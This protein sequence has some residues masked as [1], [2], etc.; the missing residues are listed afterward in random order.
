[1]RGKQNNV[2]VLIDGTRS[3]FNELGVRFKFYPH[4]F[5]YLEFFFWCILNRINPLRFKI[6]FDIN[7]LNP[8]RDIVLNFSFTTLDA[9]PRNNNK[10]VFHKY[11][12]LVFTHI[13]HYLRNTK[14]IAENISRI[15][16]NILVAE[17]NLVKN[18]YFKHFFPKEKRVYQLPFCFHNRFKNTKHFTER[19]N[20]C[21]AVGTYSKLGQE[22]ELFW[23][24]NPSFHPMRE[25]IYEAADSTISPYIDSYISSFDDARSL[26]QIRQGDS[27][28]IKWSKKYLPYFILVK[29]IPN[30]FTR[31]YQFNI[32]EKYNEYRMFI[33]PEEVFGLPSINVFEGMACGSALVAIDDQMYKD[34]GLIPSFHYITYKE[35][36]LNDLLKVVQ[37]YQNHP[38][39][40]ELI[41]RQGCE[42]IREH[43]NEESV[44]KTF[45]KDLEYF[46]NKFEKGEPAFQ[47]SFNI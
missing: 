47:C 1:M 46:S 25:K 37:Y 20:K 15:S 11:G 28:F 10:I 26:N 14:V 19:T 17:N 3:S 32:V 21:F 43:F 5:S 45:W 27:I 16:N 31:Y 34:L 24:K 22:Y 44:A 35:N 8:K 39:A 40:L 23:G 42:F 6:Y 29:I 36:D 33:S 7:K 41:A 13:T 38:A 12:G 18:I 2:A 9:F 4:F 30:F